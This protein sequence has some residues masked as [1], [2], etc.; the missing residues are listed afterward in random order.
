MDL[1][2]LVGNTILIVLGL[3]ILSMGRKL[4][5]LFVVVVGF[6][7]G[8]SLGSQIAAGSGDWV[9]LVAAVVG[10]ILGLILT[11][12]AQKLALRIVG[13]AAGGYVL[14]QILIVL[15]FSNDN[16]LIWAGI[17]VGGCLGAILI[18]SIFDIALIGLSSAL[19]SL[20]VV[21]ALTVDNPLRLIFILA[22][23]LVGIFIQTRG[24]NHDVIPGT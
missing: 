19:G 20:I 18:L 14:V 6:V 8:L 11:I 16:N 24:L 5:R 12:R 15:G 22:L 23:M 2:T 17:F 10:G 9:E 1:I 13:F 4:F 7:L 21:E 3:S